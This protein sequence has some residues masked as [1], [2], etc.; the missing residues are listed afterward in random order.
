MRDVL[1][2][3]DGKI[4]IRNFKPLAIFCVCAAWFVSD[5]VRNLKDRFS[6]KE[7]HNIFC[8]QAFAAFD[9]DQTSRIPVPDFRRVLDLFCFKMTDSQWKSISPKLQMIGDKVNYAMFLDSYTMT[10]QEVG[11]LRNIVD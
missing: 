5:L 7:T 1:D 6:C 10:E 9:K 11:L 3:I 8:F 2:C 4:Y